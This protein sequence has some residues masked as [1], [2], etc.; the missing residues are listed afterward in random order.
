MAGNIT[1]SGSDQSR[2]SINQLSED[3]TVIAG[4]ITVG[5]VSC[6]A[7]S[8]DLSIVSQSPVGRGHLGHKVG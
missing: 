5:G 8:R 4:N 7:S 2:V 1:V 6:V 3:A